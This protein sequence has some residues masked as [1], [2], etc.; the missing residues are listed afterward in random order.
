V[1]PG[2]A[3]DPTASDPLATETLA[4][5]TLAT[6]TLAPETLVVSSGRPHGAGEALNAPLVMTSTYVA[7][8]PIN[9]AREGN[10]TWAALEEALGALE[11]GHAL[12]LSSGM[13]AFNAVLD[14]V[15]P[16]GIVVA[17]THPYSGTG[18]RLREL[19]ESG[20]IT[21]REVP[22]DDTDTIIAALDNA[23]LVWMESPTNPMMEIADIVAVVEAA[24][25][26]GVRTVLDNTFATPILQRPLDLGVDITMQSGT[27]YIG[28]HSDLLLG[29]LT[30]RDSDLHEQ[31]RRRRS[32]MG[33]NPGG[34]ETWLALRGLRTLAVRMRQACANANTIALRLADHTR[35]RQV[36]YPGLP[37][38]PGHEVA[39]RQMSAGGAIVC[40]ILDGTAE[41]AERVCA[42]TTL[43]THA[44]SLGGVESTLERRG[45]WPA[46]S[47]DVPAS[48]IRLSVGI[49]D[50]DDL[51]RDLQQ[52]M[53]P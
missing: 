35:V 1:K 31:F 22:M 20:R 42:S 33:L 13:G 38:H 53:Q 17:P 10:P 16:G 47:P 49:E 28:G 14:L 39:M 41:D 50:V 4:T 48:L 9:Y 36:L 43:W 37:T 26:H 3:P 12:A 25:I 19:R 8:G 44:T 30:T 24:G 5:E 21:V 29:V 23:S 27:K 7:D 2:A 40:F 15:P 6:E 18:V 34:M 45:R 51:W 32:I 46:E 52:A 11:G